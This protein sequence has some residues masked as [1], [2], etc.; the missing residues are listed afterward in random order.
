[1]VR[2]GIS[3]WILEPGVAQAAD[4]YFA[5]RALRDMRDC[6]TV[7]IGHVLHRNIDKRHFM[8]VNTGIPTTVSSA[9]SVAEVS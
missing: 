7:A 4:A 1:M 3:C 6:V 2:A 5:A 8:E 9:Q